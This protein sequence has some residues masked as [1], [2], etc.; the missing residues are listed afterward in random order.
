MRGGVG[1]PTCRLNTLYL[2]TLL[3][4]HTIDGVN[5]NYTMQKLSSRYS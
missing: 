4:S 5:N 2:S 3:N 1:N